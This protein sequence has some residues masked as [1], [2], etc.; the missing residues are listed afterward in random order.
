M[1]QSIPP[2]HHLFSINV[3]RIAEQTSQLGLNKLRPSWTHFLPINGYHSP[4]VGWG[5]KNWFTTWTD[6]RIWVD[7]WNPSHFQ[8]LQLVTGL[9]GRSSKSPLN[10][11]HW[12]SWNHAKKKTGHHQ[13]HIHPYPIC[14]PWC[15]YI[16]T[17]MTG[18]FLGQMLG[19]IF[20]HHGAYGYKNNVN[21]G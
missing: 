10:L 15:W 1:F 3:I 16:K 19:F 14:N 20:Q 2:F 5:K 12:S 7:V 4:V 18:W 21:P 8:M 17:Y 6:P 11:S 13:S 9:P